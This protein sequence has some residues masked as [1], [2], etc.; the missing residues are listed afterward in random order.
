MVQAYLLHEDHHGAVH[1]DGHDGGQGGQRDVGEDRDEG[2]VRDREEQTEDAA[3]QPG[4]GCRCVPEDQLR[5]PLLT[6]LQYKYHRNLNCSTD[7]ISILMT[8]TFLLII[9]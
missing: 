9:K 1:L 2:E 3:E 8:K 4:G 7:H 6:K 5:G